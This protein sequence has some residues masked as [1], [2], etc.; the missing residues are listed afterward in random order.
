MF[1]S[2]QET[3]TNPRM[4]FISLANLLS[5]VTLWGRTAWEEDLIGE[6]L[7]VTPLRS[8]RGLKQSQNSVLLCR[9]MVA[10]SRALGLLPGLPQYSRCLHGTHSE[11]PEPPS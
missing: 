3:C 7:E 10:A 9:Y 5:A 4:V 2:L 1:K 8:S 6:Q 11:A